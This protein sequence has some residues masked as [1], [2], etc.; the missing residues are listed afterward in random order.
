MSY[1]FYN[2]EG[3]K[4]L[5]SQITR[6]N[7]EKG[8]FDSMRKREE[9]ICKRVECGKHYIVN[10]SNPK[11]FCSLSCAAIYNNTGRIKREIKY[12]LNCNKA[13][14]RSGYK[15]C[16]IA[17]QMDFQ[18]KTYIKKWKKG[19]VN[20]LIE[21]IGVVNKYIKRY[22]REKFEDK[23]CLCGWSQVNTV[24]NLV[25]LSA[26]HIDGNWQNNREENLRLLCPNCDSLT[27]TY[28][29]LNKG[30]GRTTR[31]IRLKKANKL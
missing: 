8:C 14:L 16:S 24:T 28:K 9:R 29:N 6:R 22:L 5:Q 19:E 20:G 26:D 27:S 7:W 3:Y 1:N 13:T 21:S 10:K 25:P 11:I 30:K 23:C 4:R 31:L 12:C 17:C 2:S 18:Y 15:Y